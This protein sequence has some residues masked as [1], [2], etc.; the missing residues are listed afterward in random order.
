MRKEKRL[1]KKAMS[2]LGLKWSD[3]STESEMDTIKKIKQEVS[4]Y[5]GLIETCLQSI[6]EYK[7]HIES[8]ERSIESLKTIIDQVE[9]EEYKEMNPNAKDIF[10]T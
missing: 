5:E 6:E 4:D 10:F 3:D 2:S 7:E 8:A 1:I 9:I